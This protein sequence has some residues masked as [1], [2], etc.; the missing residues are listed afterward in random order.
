MANKLQHYYE[1]RIMLLHL[2][3]I[4]RIFCRELEDIRSDLGADLAVDYT[5]LESAQQTIQS[6]LKHI[7]EINESKFKENY[8]KR[9]Q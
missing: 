9:D 1:K 5:D 4:M 3:T 2:K 7:N 6:Y 8:N